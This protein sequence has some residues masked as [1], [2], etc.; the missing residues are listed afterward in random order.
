MVQEALS[1]ILGSDRA[2]PKKQKS[3]MTVD[4]DRTKS[5]TGYFTMVKVLIADSNKKGH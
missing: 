1:P 5:T 3:F 4:H 2:S